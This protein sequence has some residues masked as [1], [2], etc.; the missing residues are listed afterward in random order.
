MDDLRPEDLDPALAAE[1]SDK[2]TARPLHVALLS[3]RSDPK[4][5][6]QGIWV[7]YVARALARRGHHVDIISG[8]PYPHIFDEDRP[9]GGTIAQTHLPSLDLYAQPHNGHFSLRPKHLL[10]GTDTYEY[11]GHLS[12]KFVEPFTFMQ[13]AAKLLTGKRKGRYDVVFDNQTLGK[14]LIAIAKSGTPVVGAIHHPI[15]QDLKLSLESEPKWRRRWLIRRWYTFLGMQK[16][17]ARSLENIVVVSS[18]TKQDVARDFGVAPDRMTVIPLGI[19]QEIFRPR[20]HVVRNPNRLISAAS[21]DVPLKGQRY[22][23]EA[24]AKLLETRPDL[25]LTV[26]GK[27][28]EGPTKEIARKLGISERINY[29]HGLTHEEMGEAYCSAAI[30]VT[31]SLYEGF[32]FPAAEAMA[33]GTPVV[34]TN[35]GALPEVVGDAGL[36]VE[37]ADA[38]ALADA[39]GALLDDPE[40]QAELG[41]KGRLRAEELYH[42]DNVAARYEEVFLRAIDG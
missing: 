4:V 31:P 22:L 26:I 23:I 15:T 34:V 18:S 9:S 29:I 36:I 28:R 37:K 32:G 7:D 20:A 11:F 19:D 21:A 1:L 3:Y 38:G 25:E 2:I 17:V 8:P 10:S 12:G 42:W 40:R 41:E 27:P 30:A 33:C 6:G 5:G 24:Y 13:R 16:R 39:I 35:G 14:G